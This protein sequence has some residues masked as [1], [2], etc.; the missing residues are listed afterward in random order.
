MTVNRRRWEG[1]GSAVLVL[2]GLVLLRVLRQPGLTILADVLVY[3]CII[4]ALAWVV[5]A[6]VRRARR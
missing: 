4:A 5:R 1:I 3:I 2:A 6:I